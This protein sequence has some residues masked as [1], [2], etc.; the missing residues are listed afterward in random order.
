MNLTL[1]Q[2]IV[3]LFPLFKYV[4]TNLVSIRPMTKGLEYGSHSTNQLRMRYQQISAMLAC[5]MGAK[6]TMETYFHCHRMPKPE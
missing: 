2:H 1:V 5:Q 6:L 3:P 4:E